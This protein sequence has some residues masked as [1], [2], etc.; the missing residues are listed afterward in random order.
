MDVAKI[1]NEAGAAIGKIR[2]GIT[3]E[4]DSE[5]KKLL[6]QAE[7]RIH[8][9]QNVLL[10]GQQEIIKKDQESPSFFQRGWRPMIMWITGAIFLWSFL[11]R[12]WVIDICVNIFSFTPTLSI[13]PL[14]IVSWM[15]FSFLGIGAQ[16][17][18][19]KYNKIDTKK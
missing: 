2:S 5:T 11:F 15:V 8:E 1:I 18:F 6:I 3:G 9:A 7:T 17:S 10:G 14:E 13:L 12:G 19:D 4:I 16:R